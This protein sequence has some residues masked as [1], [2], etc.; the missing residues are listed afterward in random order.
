M[1]AQPR[2]FT[3][4]RKPDDLVE[5]I[6]DLEGTPLGMAL[7]EVLRLAQEID[8]KAAKREADHVSNFR[9]HMFSATAEERAAE[10]L[11]N[12]LGS[13]DDCWFLREVAER[14]VAS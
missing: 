1:N 8:H 10:R 14:A 13:P 9:R 11:L 7:L 5:A 12:D 4:E 2:A 6:A 3:I